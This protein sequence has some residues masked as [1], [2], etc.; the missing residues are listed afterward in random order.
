MLLD[1]TATHNAGSCQQ[2]EC[3]ERE[4][5][6]PARGGGGARGSS[7]FRCRRLAVVGRA[8]VCAACVYAVAGRAALRLA[9]SAPTPP[10][11]KLLRVGGCSCFP[12]C[13]PA[14]QRPRQ[15]PVVFGRRTIYL[16]GIC[17]PEKTQTQPVSQIS[18]A[19]G[20]CLP[21]YVCACAAGSGPT[22]TYL[23][24]DSPWLLS[25][26]H[27][28]RPAVRAHG[29]ALAHLPQWPHPCQSGFT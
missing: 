10:P 11:D 21:A 8:G 23:C 17:V 5:A 20:M 15:R 19:K 3:F 7:G 4:S 1:A 14:G 12:W 18:V 22:C 24:P 28:L 25:R 9:E 27:T 6:E 26:V 13:F 16:S 29:H 2:Q